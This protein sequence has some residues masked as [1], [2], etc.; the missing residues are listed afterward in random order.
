MPGTEKVFL[1]AD[2]QDL[3][4]L[5]YEVDPRLLEKYVPAGTVLD[6]F[7]GKTYVSL[8]GFRFCHTKL[9]GSL[10]V[11]NHSDF[12]EVNLRLYVRRKEGE[13]S[14][15]GVVFIA[16]IVPK[17]AIAATARLV[18]GENY[19]CLPMKHSVTTDGSKRTVQYQWKVKKQWC[20]LSAEVIGAPQLPRDGSLEQFITEHYWGY[21]TQRSGGTVEY[22]VSHDPWRVWASAAAGFEGDATGLYGAE[23]GC[24]LQ[25]R[26]NSAFIADGS[27]VTVFKGRRLQ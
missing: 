18:Y 24:V 26:P 5:N 27:P 1:T 20:Q 19:I 14:R 16:E 7:L 21:S 15:R 11:P 8:V 9:F 25:S 2:W 12:E 22:H 6:S 13:E 17:H 23:L 10:A 3:V 4:M